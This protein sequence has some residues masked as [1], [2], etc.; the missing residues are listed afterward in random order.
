MSTAIRGVLITD[1]CCRQLL[2]RIPGGRRT[3]ASV[4]TTVGHRL[5]TLVGHGIYDARLHAPLVWK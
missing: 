5:A 2:H 4:H 1:V 3:S